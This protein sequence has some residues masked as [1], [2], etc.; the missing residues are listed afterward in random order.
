METLVK[1]KENKWYLEVITTDLNVKEFELG[2]KRNKFWKKY[3][4]KPR[5]EIEKEIGEHFDLRRVSFRKKLGEYVLF[6]IG[7]CYD[8]EI[9]MMSNTSFIH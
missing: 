4:G 6:T 2:E 7:V 3:F 8:D 1:Q 5:T 9:H